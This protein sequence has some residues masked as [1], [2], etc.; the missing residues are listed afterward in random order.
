MSNYR[1]N[2]TEFATGYDKAAA[3]IHP[4][5]VE[6]QQT[7]LQLLPQ[8]HDEAMLLVDLGGGSGRLAALF[9]ERFPRAT[10]LVVDQSEAFL[11]LAEERLAPFGGRGTTLLARLQDDWTTQLPA[12]PVAIVSMSA[13]HHLDPPEKQTLYQRCFSALAPGGVLLNGD[14]VRPADDSEYLAELRDWSA[15]MNGALEAGQIGAE[16]GP[17]LDVWRTK[18]ITNFG[19]P[20]TSGDDCHETITAQLEYYRAAGFGTVDCPWQ[21]QLWAVLRGRKYSHQPEA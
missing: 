4:H 10:V 17:I 20:K 18:N 2:K 8:A 13:I 16:M 12:P 11:A 1:W 15:H 21:K 7:I 19:G 5:Y 6:L 3:F 14:E 9:L